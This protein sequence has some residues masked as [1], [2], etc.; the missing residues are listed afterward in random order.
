[1]V[2]YMDY[3]PLDY[4]RDFNTG[5]D[6]GSGAFKPVKSDIRTFAN[7]MWERSKG[8]W[9][10]PRDFRA[11]AGQGNVATDQVALELWAAH[12]SPWKFCDLPYL[13]NA[14]IPIPG[15][16]SVNFFGMGNTSCGITMTNAGQFGLTRNSGTA[17]VSIEKMFFSTTLNKSA[18]KA[19]KIIGGPFSRVIGCRF[20]GASSSFRL[21]DALEID[22]LTPTV[23]GNYFLLT[24]NVSANIHNS[25]SGTGGGEGKVDGNWF[26]SGVISP[27]GPVAIQQN[28]GGGP[29]RIRGNLI[30]NFD[31]AYNGYYDGTGTGIG[32]EFIGNNVASC[33]TVAVNLQPTGSGATMDMAKIEGNTFNMSGAGRAL[34]IQPGAAA[35]SWLQRWRFANN[36]CILNQAGFVTTAAGVV[37]TML[38]N[39]WHGAADVVAINVGTYTTGGAGGKI[40]DTDL[41]YNITTL[42]TLNGN[43]NWSQTT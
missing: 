32:L 22:A 38:G 36:I 21:Y 40:K 10:T 4:W 14:D 8:G 19:V 13:S 3:T 27:T 23:E 41:K 11:T 30:Q 9:I 5:G 7:A 43:S 28:N 34:N 17:S 39:E 15:N 2:E 24:S 26:N 20:A 12:P 42:A 35:G 29:M 16:I 37:G 18:G 6:P 25:N 1:M 31:Y 33:R